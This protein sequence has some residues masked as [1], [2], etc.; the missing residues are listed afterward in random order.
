M[1]SWHARPG[2]ERIGVGT[3]NEWIRKND[4]FLKGIFL[5][6][7]PFQI[8]V[9]FGYLSTKFQ[10][11]W[12]KNPSQQKFFRQR[13]LQSVVGIFFVAKGFLI[14]DLLAMVRNPLLAM[15]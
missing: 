11:L 9:Y 1:S 3:C 10:G 4:G 6:E 13:M 12:S 5:L 7:S 8:Y 14:H 15:I 2:A